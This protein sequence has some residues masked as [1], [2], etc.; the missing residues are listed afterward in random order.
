[1][2]YRAYFKDSV[3]VTHGAIATPVPN[4]PKK[5]TFEKNEN[6][7]V[8]A[9]DDNNVYYQIKIVN[10]QIEV[11]KGDCSDMISRGF[12][13]HIFPDFEK[14]NFEEIIAMGFKKPEVKKE[15]E[16]VVEE[17]AKEVKKPKKQK[18]AK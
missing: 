11:I 16:V 2:F 18:A 13:C 5:K 7:Q 17:E 6:D 4:E 9:Q 12:N 15:P 1:M 8:W 14:K 3:N 10:G